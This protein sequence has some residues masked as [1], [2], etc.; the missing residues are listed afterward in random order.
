MCFSAAELC[1][2]ARRLP[3]TSNSKAKWLSDTDALA[4]KNEELKR[5]LEGKK[6]NLE[7]AIKAQVSPLSIPK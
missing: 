6:D 4:L 2:Q 1:D 3:D 7:S 5:N